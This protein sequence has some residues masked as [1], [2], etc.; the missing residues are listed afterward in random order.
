MEDGA[1]EADKQNKDCQDQNDDGDDG[2]P[3]NKQ[4]QPW[5]PLGQSMAENLLENNL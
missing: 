1:E 4:F 3:K 2:D 5:L